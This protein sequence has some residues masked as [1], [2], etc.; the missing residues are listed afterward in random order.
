M[1]IVTRDAL[2]AQSGPLRDLAPFSSQ[3]NV[4]TTVKTTEITCAD[5]RAG[6]AKTGIAILIIVPCCIRRQQYT[7]RYGGIND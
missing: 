3:H 5:Y 4:L 1:N 2:P 7:Y 6:T